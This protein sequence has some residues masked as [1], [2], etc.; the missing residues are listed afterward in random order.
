MISNRKIIWAEPL[1][2]G[3]LA[4]KVELTGLTKAFEQAKET[5]IAGVLISVGLFIGSEAF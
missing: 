4:Q 1:L 5:Q 3:M 2:E